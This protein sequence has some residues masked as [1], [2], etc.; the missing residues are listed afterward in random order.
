MILPAASDLRITPFTGAPAGITVSPFMITGLAMDA[1]NGWFACELL[2]LSGPVVR[3]LITVPEGTV[4]GVGAGVGVGVAVGV[5]VG[6]GVS[7][8][9][10]GV[11]PA[12]AGEASDFGFFLGFGLGCSAGAAAGEAAGGAEVSGIGVG[13]VSC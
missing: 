12:G 5:G 10:V 7:A 11:S 6:V 3:T 1:S 4:I 9:G 2:V 8:E 13:L